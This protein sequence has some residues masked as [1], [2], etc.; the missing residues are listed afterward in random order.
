MAYLGLATYQVRTALIVTLLLF[1]TYRQRSNIQ[2]F[3]GLG[4]NNT[5]LAKPYSESIMFSCLIWSQVGK[6]EK[7]RIWGQRTTR[8]DVSPGPGSGRQL[9]P[10]WVLWPPAPV[11]RF[12][13]R[14]ERPGEECSRPLTEIAGSWLGPRGR[15]FS[16]S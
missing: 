8:G 7:G 15:D 3:M 16:R 10:G 2:A 12:S 4:C 6:Y 9:W 13:K 11:N 5:I 14:V 1:L